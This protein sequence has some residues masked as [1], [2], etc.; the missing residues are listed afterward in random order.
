MTTCTVVHPQETS[1]W[2]LGGAAAAVSSTHAEGSQATGWISPGRTRPRVCLRCY[3]QRCCAASVSFRQ[4]QG[5]AV[6]LLDWMRGV[7]V[8][9]RSFPGWNGSDAPAPEELL[10][11]MQ[12]LQLLVRAVVAGVGDG[13]AAGEW[14][15]SR[16]YTMAAAGATTGSGSAVDISARLVCSALDL[17]ALLWWH[18]GRVSVSESIGVNGE[19]TTGP[20]DKAECTF[21]TATMQRLAHLHG[22]WVEMRRALA[23]TVRVLQ[24][25]ERVSDRAEGDAP[26]VADE[27]SVGHRDT[28]GSVLGA[29]G[30]SAI[31]SL[32]AFV[33]HE[34]SLSGA[35]DRHLTGTLSAS[36]SD[37]LYMLRVLLTRL[38]RARWTEAGSLAGMV[39]TIASLL[40]V[41]AAVQ[42]R[43]DLANLLSAL[44]LVLDDAD[45]VAAN[46][47]STALLAAPTLDTLKRCLLLP[48]AVEVRT[49]ALSVTR[50]ILQ[51]VGRWS[52]AGIA[53]SGGGGSSSSDSRWHEQTPEDA[54]LQLATLLD[55]V[56][57]CLCCGGPALVLGATP[58]IVASPD[59]EAGSP[60]PAADCPQWPA[61]ESS[62]ML[63][64]CLQVFTAAG[65]EHIRL[66][67]VLLCLEC[68]SVAL[69]AL[70]QRRQ[71]LEGGD[72][73]ESPPVMQRLLHDSLQLI[74]RCMAAHAVRSSQAA[75][76]CVSE[77]AVAVLDAALLPA[78]GLSVECLDA[79]F[80]AVASVLKD[81]LATPAAE[82]VRMH[83]VPLSVALLESVLL[84]LDAPDSDRHRALAQWLCRRAP[85]RHALGHACALC[86]STE[87]HS[88]LAD[89]MANQWAPRWV[90]FAADLP[91][92]VWERGDVVM[93]ADTTTSIHRTSVGLEWWVAELWGA[94]AQAVHATLRIESVWQAAGGTAAV[95]RAFAHWPTP[96]PSAEQRHT[97]TAE[98]LLRQLLEVAGGAP[99]LVSLAAVQRAF[100]STPEW[101]VDD[102]A[103][104][105]AIP[106]VCI[107]AY[108]ALCLD[109]LEEHDVD[110]SVRDLT[111]EMPEMAALEVQLHEA[112][113]RLVEEPA[114]LSRV[115]TWAHDHPLMYRCLGCLLSRQ[116]PQGGVRACWEVLLRRWNDTLPPVSLVLD[117][118]EAFGAPALA[119][120]L[121]VGTS[122]ASRE[123]HTAAHRGELTVQLA[124]PHIPPISRP[125]VV[126]ALVEAAVEARQAGWLACLLNAVYEEAA[127]QHRI[128]TVAEMLAAHAALAN[129]WL[130][131]GA[132]E[133]LFPDATDA[134]VGRT[135]SGSPPDGDPVI[136]AWSLLGAATVLLQQLLLLLPSAKTRNAETEAITATTVSE[137]V[138]H[139]VAARLAAV[140]RGIRQEEALRGQA[141]VARCFNATHALLLA[142]MHIGVGERYGRWEGAGDGL[143]H[144]LVHFAKIAAA[145]AWSTDG[146][147]GAA[148]KDAPA[149]HRAASVAALG[150]LAS[151]MQCGG[152]LADAIITQAI[153]P[154][155]AS[156]GDDAM[157]WL[158]HLPTSAGGSL[159]TY[160]TLR[161]VRLA[162]ERGGREAV[163]ILGG[164]GE[165]GAVA[166][167][168][169]VMNVALSDV[170]A[171]WITAELRTGIHVDE[172]EQ[173]VNAGPD[174]A[175]HSEAVRLLR[176]IMA[177]SERD[178][179]S[180][181]KGDSSGETLVDVLEEHAHLL[182][183]AGAARQVVDEGVRA[184]MMQP[185]VPTVYWVHGWLIPVD[186]P[187]TRTNPQLPPLH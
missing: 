43:H 121:T 80:D 105:A 71:H 85:A 144:Y 109:A 106:E 172:A 34:V 56:L 173:K 118:L 76:E 47:A 7:A 38:I 96:S 127:Q 157:G 115:L 140:A 37:A 183:R 84:V 63:W 104:D 35:N 62:L 153:R 112:L 3:V 86:W 98:L 49:L 134:D 136:D 58:G 15:V 60:A 132:L 171:G 100:T 2:L 169:A 186:I 64:Q 46:T 83:A 154:L 152:A 130:C 113:Q 184:R 114:R 33:E 125:R 94:G 20:R 122:N 16:A 11:G 147:T 120:A 178:L 9:A 1:Q 174:S 79:F 17:F 163:D 179:D 40:G 124:L 55:Y 12:A 129:R 175:L 146:M 69:R 25:R 74:G 187:H 6:W 139:R 116:Q 30:C 95:L 156:G 148:V 8:D 51:V 45:D 117:Y 10:Q 149:L 142:V 13:M 67:A 21:F 151:A 150:Y 61:D 182:Q 42:R 102:S 99:Q 160:V 26:D 166:A 23:F 18:A 170:H 97:R 41:R 167:F 181:S 78:M 4:R 177:L 27:D 82:S 108:H 93:A 87:T 48:D 138:L 14:A 53:E 103:M 73:R 180:H 72:S 92:D 66:R 22:A 91:A 158:R 159:L 89:V 31:Q 24:Q 88:G 143:H 65:E 5:S 68:A 19:M 126:S 54:Q 101:D 123:Q 90:V 161:T 39:P 59:E 36:A 57:E 50:R 145:H 168:H 44:S 119:K 111:S 155:G 137:R 128:G 52:T 141:L 107:V 165:A 77:V 185:A 176:A 164:R 162:V 133:C 131:A 28:T 135:E 75:M 81:A 29:V 110:D 70:E 32:L